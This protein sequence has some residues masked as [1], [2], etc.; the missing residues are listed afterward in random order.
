MPF[1]PSKPGVPVKP[2]RVAGKAAKR[3]SGERRAG[4]RKGTSAQAAQES[5]GAPARDPG[6]GARRRRR[7]VAAP[8]PR[9]SRPPRVRRRLRP[10]GLYRWVRRF[11]VPAAL[12]L[13]LCAAAVAMLAAESSQV[14]TTQ[15]VRVTA[16]VAAGDVL[17]P[18]LLERVEVDVEAVPAEHAGDLEDYVGRAVAT[19]LPAGSL[20]HPAQLVGPGLLEGH[21]PGTVAVPVRP[22]DASMIGLLSPGQHVDVTVSSDAPESSGGTQ[23]IAE[24]APVL[25][26]PQN[27]S[28]NWLGAGE[29]ASHVV[30]LAVDAETAGAI[31]EA[32]HQ[33]RL[34]LSLVSGGEE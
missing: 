27:D 18:E 30:I 12:V 13:G 19:V 34:H 5:T 29:Q 4:T 31:A 25:W 16:S 32:G 23:R 2:R 11:R 10:G 26:I 14:E 28:E 9:A 17:T 33:G 22:A 20:V 7:S 21:A 1:V 8:K 24:A 3:S 15:A 6:T